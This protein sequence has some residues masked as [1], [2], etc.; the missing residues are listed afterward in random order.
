HR[1]H[2]EPV[3]ER[4]PEQGRENRSE[5]NDQPAHRR[6]A[7]L[8]LMA[9]GTLDPDDLTDLAGLQATDDRGPEQERQE[10]GRDRRPGGPERDV[11][12]EIEDDEML[13]EGGEQVIEHR[14]SSGSVRAG[15]K[16]RKY[17][18]RRA[19]YTQPIPLNG[20]TSSRAYRRTRSAALGHSLGTREVRRRIASVV[21]WRQQQLRG[22]R[23]RARVCD[24]SESPTG[25]PRR[26]VP[27][28]GRLLVSEEQP[29]S[30]LLTFERLA[31][32]LKPAQH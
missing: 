3:G 13:A 25:G 22:R 1:D 30:Y 24:P 17:R 31:S 8:A 2:D 9:G 19:K 29:I 20:S 28:R 7:A 18:L 27:L 16:L 11:I 4:S 10:E 5:Q 23:D 15:D 32:H 6:R 12:E 14:A 21:G 26:L